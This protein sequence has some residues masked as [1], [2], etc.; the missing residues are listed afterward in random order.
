MKRIINP[1]RLSLVALLMVAALVAKSQ[2]FL[3]LTADIQAVDASALDVQPIGI[4]DD[5]W[6]VG[7]YP[8]SGG[9][10]LFV[11]IPGALQESGLRSPATVRLVTRASGLTAAGI[12]NNGTIIY[13][14]TASDGTVTGFYH[15]L[16]EASTDYLPGQALGA[17]SFQMK[18][19][20]ENWVAADVQ[21]SE[22]SVIDVL[23]F[24]GLTFNFGVNN[25]CPFGQFPS[26]NYVRAIVF[27]IGGSD[28]A[29]SSMALAFPNAELC[30]LSSR[31][32]AIKADPITGELLYVGGESFGEGQGDE[33][34][35]SA[36]AMAYG[37]EVG[38]NFLVT[39]QIGGTPGVIRAINRTG[40]IAGNWYTKATD[41]VP[42]AQRGFYSGLGCTDFSGEN[43][44]FSDIL[45]DRDVL[46]QGIND[47]NFVV[48]N[49][50]YTA[51]GVGS[52]LDRTTNR[53]FL[54]QTNNCTDR[55]AP[56]VTEDGFVDLE[57]L[58]LTFKDLT[59]FALRNV[60]GQMAGWETLNTAKAIN[61][62]NFVIGRGSLVGGEQHAYFLS[63]NPCESQP[64]RGLHAKGDF[65]FISSDNTFMH[66]QN[67]A[68]L[69]QI[70][71]A[72]NERFSGLSKQVINLD[73]RFED[74]N[75]N[76]GPGTGQ[77]WYV[78]EVA[79]YGTE[80][81][82]VLLTNVTK[83]YP[84]LA[85]YQ[86]IS[87]PFSIPELTLFPWNEPVLSFKAWSHQERGVYDHVRVEIRN[88]GQEEWSTLSFISE[89]L[90]PDASSAENGWTSYFV[91]VTPWMNDDDMAELR[92]TFESDICE[93]GDGIMFKDFR[94]YGLSQE[95]HYAEFMQFMDERGGDDLV[96]V[97]E[98]VAG[99]LAGAA[100]GTA[101]GI[102]AGILAKISAAIPPIAIGAAIGVAVGL[103]ID[104]TYDE[105]L[106][107]DQEAYAVMFS[108]P[109]ATLDATPGLGQ[110]LNNKKEAFFD[111]FWMIGAYDQ[112]G[113]DRDLAFATISGAF[114]SVNQGIRDGS[115]SATRLDPAYITSLSNVQA[116]EI[117][118]V[119]T[120]ETHTILTQD[121]TRLCLKKM[122]SELALYT[123]S[124]IVN[125]YVYDTFTGE[126]LEV[127]SPEDIGAKTDYQLAYGMALAALESATKRWTTGTATYP[128]PDVKEE[129]QQ[130]PIPDLKNPEDGTIVPAGQDAGV[131]DQTCRE[132]ATEKLQRR[133]R[134]TNSDP[135]VERSTL[136]SATK[137]DILLEAEQQP[138]GGYTVW[139]G[140]S[141]VLTRSEEPKQSKQLTTCSALVAP[142]ANGE[143]P[144]NVQ[145]RGFDRRVFMPYAGLAQ[146]DIG[147][148]A[149]DL[150]N[151]FVY[152]LDSNYYDGTPI[153][154]EIQPGYTFERAFYEKN[155][156]GD[157]AT[158][159]EAMGLRNKRKQEQIA[160]DRLLK[161]DHLDFERNE[162][163]AQGAIDFNEPF[164]QIPANGYY[165]VS[166]CARD[167]NQQYFQEEIGISIIPNQLSAVGS[168]GRQRVVFDLNELDTTKDAVIVV[169][170]ASAIRGSVHRIS[171]I[172]EDLK[173]RNYLLEED[174]VYRIERAFEKKRLAFF[175]R[176]ADFNTFVWNS[177]GYM[178]PDR[179]GVSRYRDIADRILD[180]P[181]SEGVE[182]YD[183]LRNRVLHNEFPRAYNAMSP[184]KPLWQADKD[185]LEGVIARFSA[186]AETVDPALGTQIACPLPGADAFGKVM[187]LMVNDVGI[188]RVLPALT[189]ILNENESFANVR[190]RVG[191]FDPVW[192]ENHDE[193]GNVTQWLNGFLNDLASMD[194][195]TVFSA[196]SRESLRNQVYGGSNDQ[197]LLQNTVQIDMA[198]L[199]DS[200]EAPET[201]SELNPNV[202][203][204]YFYSLGASGDL[205]ISHC[206]NGIDNP[207][208]DF[209]G[210]SD[211]LNCYRT[212]RKEQGLT[213]F[214]GYPGP[215]C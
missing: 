143:S 215:T 194:N 153:T 6:V 93:V 205:E 74:N 72:S 10:Q 53:A 209:L 69:D 40:G 19:I 162:I 3:D 98:I 196:N 87:L 44:P 206:Q 1:K 83:G 200:N 78:N 14:L 97:G 203:L 126:Y 168:T 116:K 187:Y 106:N 91:D 151:L 54:Y 96:A 48:G 210:F 76:E 50:L 112:I 94:L 118:L 68:R 119:F 199:N 27:N 140:A 149:T 77:G 16:D 167:A 49:F 65:G 8:T 23:S 117:S 111:G 28:G 192:P 141:G 165:K 99:T 41:R 114:E 17:E 104:Y 186:A 75:A 173:I 202:L 84:N 198:V 35:T 148:E 183:D 197:E 22:G 58:N 129:E 81:S 147:A 211:G 134:N 178:E 159:M 31:A 161:I 110:Y 103:G 9:N 201:L 195:V 160:D 71:D 30:N 24:G 105:V 38:D 115:V 57:N 207:A 170:G 138:C 137:P 20:S 61:N 25:T 5:G 135:Q 176:W 55:T 63:L 204:H 164:R 92:F 166:V 26:E 2:E 155:F 190:I 12:S 123:E 179:F 59:N 189:Q 82:A 142:N 171:E 95:V 67:R 4:N 45:P 175:D 121:V 64:V 214:V 21:V 193:I 158:T 184:T 182:W 128:Y 51:P 163:A 174:L 90:D 46:P 157:R 80:E 145:N 42:N 56:P 37:Q 122:F 136:R 43:L 18:A 108:A 107:A 120:T 139:F 127:T 52:A 131:L 156:F 146:F 62:N 33:K 213:P 86:I 13:N 124:I 29:G 185:Y 88:R 152:P 60:G 113:T 39:E 172:D 73:D 154:I 212:L 101:G 177:P 191:L 125:V 133:S 79:E 109:T 7:H 66:A 188:L 32:Y 89:S 181:G 130:V 47:D 132:S 85:N 144:G 150:N 11:W 102:A 208:T 70:F 36:R 34:Y 180:D 169:P 15:P 100:E